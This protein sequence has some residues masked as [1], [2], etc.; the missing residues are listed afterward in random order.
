METKQNKDKM[1]K[2]D[3]VSSDDESNQCF[4]VIETIDATPQEVLEAIFA[5]ADLP[6]K[7]SGAV[8]DSEN[9]RPA[10]E[11]CVEGREDE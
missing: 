1:E 11:G 9:P 4:D 7:E 2:I 10:A 3:A 5:A 8:T 6:E